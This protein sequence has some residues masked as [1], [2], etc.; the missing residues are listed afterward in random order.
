MSDRVQRALRELAAALEEE[1]TSQ[2]RAPRAEAS[3]KR[4]ASPS[5]SS[6]TSYSSWIGGPCERAASTR[7]RPLA[8]DPPVQTQQ[9][10][11]LPLVEHRLISTWSWRT[12]CSRCEW[13]GFG[14]RGFNSTFQAGLL[15]TSCV[16][17]RRVATVEDALSLWRKVRPTQPCPEL[18]L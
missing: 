1:A 3:P 17:L 6:T 13:D 7:V 2:R 9:Q 15:S 8:A 18:K 16:R 14:P 4:C 11:P 12:P 5:A 10:L